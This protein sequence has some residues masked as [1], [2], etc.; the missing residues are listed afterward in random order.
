MLNKKERLWNKNI[1]NSVRRPLQIDPKWCHL[2]PTPSINQTSSKKCII[3]LLLNSDGESER[4]SLLVAGQKRKRW[5]ISVCSKTNNLISDW[6]PDSE[7]TDAAKSVTFPAPA[8]SLAEVGNM[9]KI[10]SYHFF[11]SGERVYIWGDLNFLLAKSCVRVEIVEIFLSKIC[12]KALQV[13]SSEAPGSLT[14]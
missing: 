12:L 3:T 13:G 1:W 9:R 2:I 11:E 8:D 7:W 10:G 5:Y 6:W 14:V 4:L